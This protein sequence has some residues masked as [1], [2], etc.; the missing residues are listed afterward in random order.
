[1]AYVILLSAILPLQQQS[2]EAYLAESGPAYGHSE[3]MAEWE[4]E[5][6]SD[7]VTTRPVFSL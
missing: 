3:T 7:T 4:L 1:M 2:Y 5:P 6:E